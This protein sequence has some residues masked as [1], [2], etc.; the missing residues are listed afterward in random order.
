M[1]TD[2]FV[3]PDVWKRRLTLS[4]FGKHW[5]SGEGFPVFISWHCFKFQSKIGNESVSKRE[6]NLRDIPVASSLFN[7]C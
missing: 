6:S 2:E 1:W 7:V 3:T 5:K 4:C